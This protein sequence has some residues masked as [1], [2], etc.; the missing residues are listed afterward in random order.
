MAA[1][2]QNLK[3]SKYAIFTGEDR[4]S[5]GYD[6]LDRV[7]G[8]RLV[9]LRIRDGLS[10]LASYPD[11]GSKVETTFRMGLKWGLAYFSGDGNK[12]SVASMH[13][14]GYEQYQRRI[15]LERIRGRIGELPSGV[16]F[17]A[18]L[19]LDDRSSNH[20]RSEC[21]NYDDCQLLQLTD[22]LVGG[23]RTALGHPTSEIHDQLCGPLKRLA[24]DGRLGQARMRNSRWNRGYTIREAYIENGRWQFGNVGLDLPKAQ[25]HLF[26]REKNSD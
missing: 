9:V 17:T 22:V 14:D 21:Q 3:G 8:L 13:F 7:I 11:H 16:A 26:A 25:T 2:I 23:F 10:A 15:D 19:T 5:P 18:N 20:R 4:R 12:M 24:A 6:V 1:L